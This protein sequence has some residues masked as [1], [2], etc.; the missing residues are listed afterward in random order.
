MPIMVMVILGAL[1]V[2]VAAALAWCV[3]PLLHARRCRRKH[4]RQPPG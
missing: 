4:G 3:S 1:G 2:L